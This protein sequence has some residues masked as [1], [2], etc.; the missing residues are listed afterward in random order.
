MGPQG[1][2]PAYGTDIRVGDLRD[3]FARSFQDNPPAVSDRAWTFTPSI[4]ITETYD[5]AVQTGRGFR[6]DY[7][8]RVTPNLAG[9]INTRRIEGVLNYSPTFSFYALNGSQNGVSHNLNAYATVTAVENLLFLDLRGYAATTPLLGGVTTPGDTG[10]RSNE[11][12]TANFSASPYM[13]YRFGDVA[14]ARI[15]YTIA[16]N[17]VSS[18]NPTGSAAA[19]TGGINSNYTSQQE[20]LNVTS[21]PDF[22]RIQASLDATALQYEG[23]GLYKGAHNENAA[24]SAGYALTRTFTVTGSVGHEN[25]VYGPGGPKAITGITWS[26]GFRWA[27]NADSVINASYGHQQGAT[28]VSFDGSYA[29]TARLRLSARYSQGVGTGLQNLQNALAGTTVGTAGITVD[30]VTGAPV[31]L[32]DYLGQQAGVYRTTSASLSAVLLLDRD[33]ISL[34][35]EK[36]ERKLLSGGPVAGGFN[37]GIGSNDALTGS[38]AWQHT[39]TEALSTSTYL[40][41]GVRSVPGSGSNATISGSISATYTLSATV[42]TNLLLSHTETSGPTFGL[43][44]T[45]ELVVVGVHKAI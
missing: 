26:G 19:L 24:L 11:V 13:K 28:S 8:T 44:P 25:I 43:P 22:G 37:P 38:I 7:I 12:Q 39:L 31:R 1:L 35:V 30:R 5:S 10:G 29:P 41:Y 27:P 2:L 9:T 14:T 36:T 34:T 16:R 40:Q 4:D 15:G 42:S 3:Q 6:K 18:L 45:R 17:V 33:V 32:D 23:S 21:G 20:S